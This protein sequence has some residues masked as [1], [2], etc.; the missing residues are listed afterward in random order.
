VINSPQDFGRTLAGVR[1]ARG[2]TQESLAEM[3]GID[4]T[5]LAKLEAGSETLELQRLLLALRRLG[6]EV[7]VSLTGRD[8]AAQT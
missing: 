1:R 5:Y 4:R 8:D 6:A 3:T 2:V 7:T